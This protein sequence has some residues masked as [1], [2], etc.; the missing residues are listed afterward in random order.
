MLF[1]PTVFV[2]KNEYHITVVTKVHSQVYVKIGKKYFYEDNCGV[3]PVLDDVHKIKVKQSVLDKAGSYQVIVRKVIEKSSYWPKYDNP[4]VYEYALKND[5]F[6]NIKACYLADVHNNYEGAKKIVEHCGKVD[7]FICNGDL[8]ECTKLD[9]IL[10][11]SNFLSDIAKG[12]IPVLFVRGNHD[13]RGEFAEVLPKY[14]G[15]DGFNGYFAFSFRS[16]CGIALDCGEDKPDHNAEYGGNTR[17]LFGA[18][19]FEL[20]RKQELSFIKRAKLPENKYRF[21]VCHTSFM[22]K[23]SMHGM[24]DIDE[25]TYSAWA[26]AL[27]AKNLDF[28]IC[29]HIHKFLYSPSSETADRY[30]HNYPVVTGSAVNEGLGGTLLNFANGN[31]EFTFIDLNG[32]VLQKHAVKCF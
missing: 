1:H 26:E 23:E 4:E 5:N 3:L 7:L 16:L 8:G 22:L 21:G 17:R 14:T 2:V 12:C 9:E 13:A 18:N 6:D 29:G 32:K 30:P 25:K 31:V 24:F 27:N 11:L 19:R 20:Y 28:M 15:M 10:E